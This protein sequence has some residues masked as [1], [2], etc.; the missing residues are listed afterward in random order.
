[1]CQQAIEKLLKAV[2]IKQKKE[3]PPRIHNLL[4]LLDL[5]KLELS[6]S[7]KSLLFKLNQFYVESRYP[8][9]RSTLSKTLNEEKAKFYLEQ[10]KEVFQCLREMLPSNK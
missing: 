10:T 4:Y 9:E 2:Y 8:D 3:Q 6:E 5:L 7:Y 1:M